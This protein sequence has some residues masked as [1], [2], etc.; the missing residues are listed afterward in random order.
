MPILV[1]VRNPIKTHVNIKLREGSMSKVNVKYENI[2]KICFK[3]DRLGHRLM[4]CMAV[5]SDT[6]NLRYG[7]WLRESLWK[8]VQEHQEISQ[9]L[10]GHQSSVRKN[11]FTLSREALAEVLNKKDVSELGCIS[12]C[13]LV[14]ILKATQ[15]QQ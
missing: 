9:D 8:T 14:L 10:P 12:G 2:P 1:D 3:C 15:D 4:D 11:L 5:S 7:I 13:Q 6:K